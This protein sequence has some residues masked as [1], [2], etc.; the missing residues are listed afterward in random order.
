MQILELAALLIKKKSTMIG[1]V[2]H[3]VMI[4][5]AMGASANNCTI[6]IVALCFHQFSEGMGLGGSILQVNSSRSNRL[7]TCWFDIK[8]ID[9]TY[10]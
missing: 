1:I 5:L 2:V 6:L 3:S 7:Y 9:L 8:Q 4:G 10:I